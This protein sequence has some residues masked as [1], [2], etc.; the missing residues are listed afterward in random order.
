M[1]II[2]FRYLLFGFQFLASIL[3][4]EKLSVSE[5]Y[6]FG[7]FQTILGTLLYLQLGLPQYFTK[8]NVS[9]LKEKSLNHSLNIFQ[10]SQIGISIIL[11]P[12]IFFFSAYLSK[13]YF[14]G[15]LITFNF[16]IISLFNVFGS[17]FRIKNDIIYWLL[18]LNFYCVVTVFYLILI[19]SPVLVELLC[20]IT[21]INLLLLLCFYKRTLLKIKTLK[22]VV[23]IKSSI[24]QLIM[25]LGA[26]FLIILNRY[27][28]LT[29]SEIEYK[30]Y[31]EAF[32]V[33]MAGGL[34]VNSI[35]QILSVKILK[36]ISE[37]NIN[38]QKWMAD[39][40]LFTIIFVTVIGYLF[41]YLI[42]YKYT[43]LFTNNVLIYFCFIMPSLVLFFYNYLIAKNKEFYS[44]IPLAFS[45]LPYFFNL[46]YGPFIYLLLSMTIYSISF[47]GLIYSFNDDL[48]KSILYLTLRNIFISSLVII[49]L[50][51]LNIYSYVLLI[52]FLI[53][54][55]K[56]FKQYFKNFIEFYKNNSTFHV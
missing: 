41:S 39:N 38:K 54:F 23:L 46:K 27:L 40:L 3:I 10:G 44:L 17:Y 22:F 42:P 31:Q 53:F 1:R 5:I 2:L 48:S 25:N 20:Y 56:R 7:I 4:L 28:A 29:G 16:S 6:I 35:S 14:I 19:P 13:S 8:V 55:K 50:F 21:F 33:L 32:V 26:P 45:L 18:T 43:D 12:V 47:A 15:F 24:I 34:V 11:F 49:V 37:N 9:D 36:L 30:I 52:L 51:F